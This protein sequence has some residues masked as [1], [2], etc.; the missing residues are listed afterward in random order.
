MRNFIFFILITVFTVNLS[1]SQNRFKF[2]SRSFRQER[3]RIFI[4]IG[5][6]NFLG[7]FGGANMI[8]SPRGSLR[9]FDIQAVKPAFQIGYSYRM[10]KFLSSRTAF[11]YSWLSGNDAYTKEPFRQ[12][13]NLN[14]R[15]P[16]YDLSS[17]IE[18]IW[19]I[20]QKGH[21]Y[22]LK[23]VKGWKNYRYAT[24]IY[25]GVALNYFNSKGKYEGVWHALRPLSTE[26]QGL[27]PSRKKVSPI[28][29]TIPLGVGVKVRI[30]RT[31]E[32][33]IEYNAR[34]GFTDY[35]DDVSTTYFDKNAL[36]QAKGQLAV[37]MSDPS[38]NNIPGA[39][40]AGQQRGDPRDR[41]SYL[42]VMVSMYYTI[43]KGFI[44]RLRNR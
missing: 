15:T 21:Q 33:G 17:V 25:G 44:P 24:Y 8:G 3:H 5:A 7:D 40:A 26:G 36:L 19:E 22:Y 35:I 30:S 9:D 23:G 20:K 13:R 27:I 38:L 11:T 34:I 4:S 12:N 31:I 10:S 43:G 28:Q 6:T 29:F 16:V 14:F 1:F 37:D 42:A 18:I 2:S 32:I 41:D 39:T